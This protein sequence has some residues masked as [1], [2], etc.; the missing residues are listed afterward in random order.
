M[1][2]HS[3]S[4]KCSRS[5]TLRVPTVAQRVKNPTVV[6]LRMW[7]QSLAPLSG[8][9]TWHCLKLW[10]RLQMLLESC[11]AVAKASS[12]RSDLTPRLGTSTCHGC[13]LKKKKKKKKSFK[14][15]SF[16]NHLQSNN[17]S[18]PMV[19]PKMQGYR[20]GTEIQEDLKLL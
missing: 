10:S 12:C 4:Q 7:F 11:I 2:F 6:S 5:F 15:I 19:Y 1:A 17:N 3:S 20:S 9:R 13:G 8:L 16:F 18:F 14:L